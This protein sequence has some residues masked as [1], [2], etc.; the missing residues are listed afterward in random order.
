MTQLHL[1]GPVLHDTVT[2]TGTGDEYIPR[3]VDATELSTVKCRR[4]AELFLRRPIHATPTPNLAWKDY[5]YPQDVEAKLP[6]W[7]RLARRRQSR[8]SATAGS[9]AAAAL[10][11]SPFEFGTRLRLGL[12][13]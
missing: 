8:A 3:I 5:G 7:L 2:K 10:G 11:P 9:A 1:I 6:Q 13:K 4:T 12:V